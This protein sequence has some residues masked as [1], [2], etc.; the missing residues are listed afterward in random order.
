MRRRRPAGQALRERQAAP[1][2]RRPA[3]PSDR[4]AL[5]AAM[6]TDV[7]ATLKLAPTIDDVVVVTARAERRGRSPRSY[8]AAGRSRRPARGGHS[9][10][11][12]AA[13]IALGARRGRAST[14]SCSPATR[15][16]SRR[17]RSTSC[18]RELSDGPEVVIVPDRHGTGTN[19]LL[20]T[21]PDVIEPSFGDGSRAR[22][23]RLAREARRDG[24][25]RR[26]PVADA[27][28]RH[29]RG[30]RRA[31][32]GARATRR[33]RT[34]VYTRDA[35][36]PRAPADDASCTLV[37]LHGI[38][39]IAPG[40]RPRGAA[41]A[42]RPARRRP[43]ARRRARRRPQGRLEG[44]GRASSTSPTSRR[45]RARASSPRSTARTRARSRS[46]S[47]RPPRSCASG[48]AC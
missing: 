28:R 23:E 1:R 30:P 13:A 44:R 27:R 6:L 4:V 5:A 3:A 16:L 2:R 19:A 7:L 43:G 47:T 21:P 26:D 34:A 35:L 17:P 24:A 46:C 22:H 12:R 40:R 14:C 18:S 45:P 25:G 48:P 33:A 36:E 41:R 29:A 10:A 37:P 11:A 15:R 9:A 38:P 32:R 42:T 8:G 39:E 20:L 31:R